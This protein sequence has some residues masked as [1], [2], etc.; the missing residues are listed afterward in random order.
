MNRFL[1]LALSAALLSPIYAQTPYRNRS[2]YNKQQKAVFCKE[3]L[4]VFAL[5][6]DSNPTNTESA[7][8][9][10]C[11]WNKLPESGHERKTAIKILNGEDPGWFYLRVLFEPRFGKAIESCGVYEL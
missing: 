4:P 10:T 5:D 9:C 1:L 2:F 7:E 11:I 8:L 6:D 3:P